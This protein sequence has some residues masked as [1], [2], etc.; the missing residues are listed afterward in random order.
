MIYALWEFYIP[1]SALCPPH[2]FTWNALFS[3][4]C[5]TIQ[6]LPPRL[7]AF[8]FALWEDLTRTVKGKRIIVTYALRG[9]S[10]PQWEGWHWELLGVAMGAHS[11]ACSHRHVP[12][13]RELIAEVE[14]NLILQ[15][16]SSPHQEIHFLQ[17]GSSL[18]RF[19][20]LPKQWHPLGTKYPNAWAYG[21]I[22]YSTCN[23]F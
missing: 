8:P 6:T 15:S 10:P 18:V 11:M 1:T 9:Y 2:P 17:L 4:S 19:Q 21:S 12:G 16:P 7:A 14:L 22:L 3:F 20:N 13:N 5:P 23:I